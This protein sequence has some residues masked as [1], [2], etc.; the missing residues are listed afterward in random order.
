[1]NVLNVDVRTHYAYKNER[2]KTFILKRK[3]FKFW[4]LK[5]KQLQP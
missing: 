5:K 4:K 2:E 1:M 3:D